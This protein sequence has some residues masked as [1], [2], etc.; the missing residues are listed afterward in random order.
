MAEH[1]H[2]RCL[3]PWRTGE[4][5][6]DAD[7]TA[8]PSDRFGG[9]VIGDREWLASPREATT[10]AGRLNPARTNASSAAVS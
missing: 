9:V 7:A 1:M 6:L 8:S 3:T 4:D 5:T 2:Q 10:L